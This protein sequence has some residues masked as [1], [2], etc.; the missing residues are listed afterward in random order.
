MRVEISGRDR[1]LSSPPSPCRRSTNIARQVLAICLINE[2]V[3]YRPSEAIHVVRPS[4]GRLPY[5]L[6]QKKTRS[7][8]ASVTASGRKC[9]DQRERGDVDKI[10]RNNSIDRWQSAASRLSNHPQGT[11][12][13][14]GMCVRGRADGRSPRAGGRH[15]ASTR[16][17]VTDSA[18]IGCERTM[19]YGGY[20]GCSRSH[21]H[22]QRGLKKI[23]VRRA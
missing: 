9:A 18:D 17:T 1:W 12:G 5:R 21:L 7:L 20:G 14:K 6:L 11:R 13:S 8:L 16:P 10:Y 23:R 15:G 2:Q 4:V 22:V 3:R 19:N